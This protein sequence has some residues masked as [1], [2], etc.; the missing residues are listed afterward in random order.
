M[1][2]SGWLVAGVT[3]PT[4]DAGLSSTWVAVVHQV[5]REAGGRVVGRVELPGPG[6]N[7][8]RLAVELPDGGR[9]WVLLNAAVRLVGCRDQGEP[10][11][12]ALPIR[13]VPCANLFELA[14]FRVAMSD[15]LERPAGTSD[16]VGLGPGEVA[17]IE[18]HRPWRVGD[19]IYNWF[20]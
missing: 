19:V 2:E 9:V 11:V 18:Y 1:T 16:F 17:D 12:L 20:D 5:A 13:D 8:Y 3:S 4:V 7:Y 15:E 14:G 10:G 6:R